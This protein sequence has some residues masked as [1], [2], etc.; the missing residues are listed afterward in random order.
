[1]LWS[2]CIWIAF[3]ISLLFTVTKVKSKA[4]SIGGKDYK[5][6]TKEQYRKFFLIIFIFNFINYNV[7][8]LDE[9][10]VDP[11]IIITP[12]PC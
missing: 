9:L 7:D 11:S 10:L 1:M 4:S 6:L 2:A 12:H 8:N 3:N 5:K